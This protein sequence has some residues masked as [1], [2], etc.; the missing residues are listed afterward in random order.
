VKLP[1]SDR[2]R[3]D[4][5]KIWSYLLSPTHPVGRF[6]ARGFAAWASTRAA[7]RRLFRNSAESPRLAKSRRSKT[8]SSAGSTLFLAT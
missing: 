1:E 5:Q 2:V 8:R 4:E 3:I 6:K 7:H